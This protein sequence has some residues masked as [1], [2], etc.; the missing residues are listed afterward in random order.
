MIRVSMTSLVL[1]LVCTSAGIVVLLWLLGEW[2]RSRREALLRSRSK[3]CPLCFFE[4]LTA[5]DLPRA[6]CPRC[7][8]PTE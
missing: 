2:R 5:P 3:K 1:V 7:G 8:A 6:P 4:F